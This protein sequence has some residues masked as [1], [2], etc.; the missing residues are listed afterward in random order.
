MTHF[1][2]PWLCPRLCLFYTLMHIH[3][4]LFN[5]RTWF[6]LPPL[7]HSVGL[8]WTWCICV[9]R[10]AFQL[11]SCFPIAAVAVRKSSQVLLPPKITHGDH[12]LMRIHL[13]VKF[14][15]CHVLSFKF[16]FM[17]D[18]VCL[19]RRSIQRIIVPEVPSL[20]WKRFIATM[21]F[22]QQGLIPNLPNI[23]PKIYWCISNTLL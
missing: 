14:I 2:Q 1:F 5:L 7:Y 9:S 11:K 22:P 15:I 16:E 20:V 18:L 6:S 10:A 4:L 19:V 3:T 23:N 13:D 17:W 21:C 12:L 8:T